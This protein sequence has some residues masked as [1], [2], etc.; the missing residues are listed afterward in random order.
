MPFAWL[1]CASLKRG[2]DLYSSLFL[3]WHHLERMTLKNFVDLWRG[4]PVGRWLIN[5]VFLASTQS[6][7]VVLLSSAGGFA[8]AKY[9]FAGKRV[10]LAMILTTMVLPGQVLLPGSY[11]LIWRIGWLDSYAAILVPG[12][13]SAFGILLFRQA[14]ANVPD[15]LLAAARVD[16]CS[17]WRLW[18]DIAL[19]IVRPMAGAFTLLTFIASWNSFLWPSIVLQDEGKYTLPIGLA[20]LIG[21]PEMTRNYSLLMAAT[22]ISITPVM[23]LFFALQKE[24][25]AG[26]TSGAVKG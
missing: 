25:V 11:E 9:Q 14:M 4:Q 12:A 26:L 3:P 2:D 1:I 5:S 10:L 21:Q 23:V 13:V 24:F 22:L 7:C 17:E 18:W 15:E 16:G 20:N 8:L 19:P 6:V